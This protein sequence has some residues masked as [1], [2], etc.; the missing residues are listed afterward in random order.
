MAADSRDPVTGAYIFSDMG[1]P[2]IGVDPTLVSEQANDVGTRIIR[3]NL[4]GLEA[5]P[6][7]RAG[8]MGHALDTK[9]DYVHD[10][11]GWLEL[12]GAT[13][14]PLTGFSLNWSGTTGFT[15][16]LVVRG[17]TRTLYGAVSR[18]GGAALASML[19]V[20]DG[21]RPA[22]STFLP[23]N[24]TDGGAA[25]ALQVLTTGV[26]RVPYGGGSSAAAYPLAG[27]WETA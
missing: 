13:V 12:N 14:V 8:L 6:Y 26:L 23:G 17:K 5:Y 24:V 9:K 19:V 20:P 7:K 21:H 18:G 11:S 10:G 15:P 22:Q 27:T 4:A 16:Y 25:Y 3:A 2:D 1:A